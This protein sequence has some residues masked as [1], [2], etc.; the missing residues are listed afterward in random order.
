MGGRR[1]WVVLAGIALAIAVVVLLAPLGT[2]ESCTTTGDGPTVCTRTGVSLLAGQGAGVL[3]PLCLPALA[4]LLP[5]LLRP[6]VVGGLVAAVL[7]SFC[8]LTG[9][10]IGLFFVP[11]AVGAIVLAVRAPRS[12]PPPVDSAVRA[13]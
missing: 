6:R 10:T 1:G 12:A 7:L 8:V 5:A 11:V 13:G 2:A 4:C 9:F 3:V